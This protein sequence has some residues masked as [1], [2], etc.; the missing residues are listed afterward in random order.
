MRGANFRKLSV[1]YFFL[2]VAA[3][4]LKLAADMTT[5][6]FRT[7]GGFTLGIGIHYGRSRITDVTYQSIALGFL[8]DQ[9]II[10]QT[11]IRLQT[12]GTSKSLPG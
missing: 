11:S 7:L 12:T 10:T 6:A 8:T 3:T 1:P 2:S 5:R 4:V 9:Q